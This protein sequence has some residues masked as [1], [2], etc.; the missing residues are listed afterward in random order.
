MGAEN[1]IIEKNFI[2]GAWE[3]SGGEKIAVINPVTEKPIG[4]ICEASARDVDRAVEAANAA[5]AAWSALTGA[6]RAGF[7]R[8]MTA[9][10]RDHLDDLVALQKLNCG[11]PPVEA[12]ADI[13]GSIECIDYFAGQAEALDARRQSAV[14]YD[15]PGM[16]SVT[17]LEPM[18][19]AGF[20]LPWNFPMKICAWKL[21]P[22]LAAGC[23]VVIKPSEIAPF[24]DTFWG[25]AATEAGL[26]PG[27]LNV[28]NGRGAITGAALAENEELRKIA[29]TGSTRTGKAVMK[30]ATN[31][32]K[33]IGLELGGKSPIV[34]FEDA[35]LDLAARLAAEGVFYNSGQCCNA[36][37]R[38]L[39]QDSIKEALAE[40]LLEV[41]DGV[42]LGAPDTPGVT[43]GPLAS[44]A[45]YD[46]VTGYMDIA[47]E[48][49]LNCRIGGGPAAQFNSGYFVEPTLYTDVPKPSRLWHEEI[50]GPVLCLRSFADEAEA[51][52][53][54]NDTEYGLAA[55]IVTE[56]EDQAARVAAQLEAGHVYTN[57]SV[58]IPPQT[59]WGG[60]KQSGI[61][62]ELGPWG[63]AG[64][65]EVKT[66]TSRG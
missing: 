55:T 54:A 35:D 7:M 12:E 46:K 37:C 20:I 48:E 36:T 39:V 23:T 51:V 32:V 47:R 63:L 25:V 65:L 27:V 15:I 11:K 19:S 41:F 44:Q 22:A 43:M 61:G 42:V 45:Q 6:E 64:F 4:H 9:V 49:G 13:I 62:R 50:F 17:R 28:V 14:D 29:F 52:R 3:E 18:G 59:S 24:T 5:F 33:N 56:D 30:A 57:T 26:P 53:E 10:I 21:G 40:K 31:G 1:V 38:L 34:V 8:K 58:A 2:N 60:F 16:S 66:V